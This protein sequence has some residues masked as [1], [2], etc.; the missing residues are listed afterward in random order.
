MSEKDTFTG[1]ERHEERRGGVM[2]SYDLSTKE[3]V[4]LMAGTMHLEV[5]GRS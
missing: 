5:M 3:E 1:T 4:H 2:I